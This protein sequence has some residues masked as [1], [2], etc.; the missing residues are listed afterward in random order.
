MIPVHIAQGKPVLPGYYRLFL[1]GSND[2]TESASVNATRVT[3]LPEQESSDVI[4]P[5]YLVPVSK[6]AVQDGGSYP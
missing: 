5:D 4:I 2:F 6:G 3:W 1:L